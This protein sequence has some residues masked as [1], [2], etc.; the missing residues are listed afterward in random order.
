MSIV[1]KDM[2][3]EDKFLTEVEKVDDKFFLKSNQEDIWIT[4][5]FLGKICQNL[6]DLKPKTNVTMI[7]KDTKCN[8]AVIVETFVW[9]VQDSELEVI[10]I[11]QYDYTNSSNNSLL[12]NRSQL[13][14]V[15][16]AC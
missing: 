12:I 8:K 16:A 14:A 3:Q 13:N 5:K 4:E 1:Y 9:L 11:N 2:Q 7:A 15:L 6:K 10:A